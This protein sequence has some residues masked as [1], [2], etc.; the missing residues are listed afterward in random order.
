MLK[1]KTT[2]GVFVSV[3]VKMPFLFF[4]HSGTTKT[5]RLS[6]SSPFVGCLR[7]VKLNGKPVSLEKGSRRGGPVSVHKCPAY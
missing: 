3:Y 1:K 4:F 5:N 2:A 7:N 6:V